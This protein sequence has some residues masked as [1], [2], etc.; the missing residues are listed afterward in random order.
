RIFMNK[1]ESRPTAGF[2]LV[3]MFLMMEQTNAGKGHNHSIFVTGINYQIISH[4]STR[5]CD[6]FYTTLMCSLNVVAEREESIRS[7]R[8]T[9]H[10]I[11]PCSLLF[12]CEHF[13]LL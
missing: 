8:H 3:F 5:L 7:Q 2:P 1:R 12:S 10:L 6:I 4:R 13:R 11:Q 9:G